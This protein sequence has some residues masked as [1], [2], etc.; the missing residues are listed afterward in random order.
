MMDSVRNAML[1]VRAFRSSPY[2]VEPCLR[3]SSR[4]CNLQR[5]YQ[6]T[7]RLT[8]TGAFRVL[9]GITHPS[10]PPN[11]DGVLHLM[12]FGRASIPCLENFLRPDPAPPLPIETLRATPQHEIAARV[13]SA[14]PPASGWRVYGGPG[15]WR[16][17]GRRQPY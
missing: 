17:V 5:K 9:S 14:T 8:T 11:N 16:A 12:V 3:S 13:V 2:P 6:S 10:Q 7:R 1:L 15:N 4:R